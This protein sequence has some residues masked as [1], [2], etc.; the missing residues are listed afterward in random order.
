LQQ[1]PCYGVFETSDG[2][3]VSLASVEPKF[4]SAFLDVI[5]RPDLEGARFATGDQGRAVRAE[6]SAVIGS[7]SLADWDK[8]F[9]N[10]DVCYAPVLTAAEGYRHP[11]FAD[12]PVGLIGESSGVP[13]VGE[14]NTELFETLGISVSE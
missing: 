6:I 4:W 3:F 14:A 9:L 11:Q 7:R 10:A 1:C 8:L 12:R 13:A 5:Y 2:R